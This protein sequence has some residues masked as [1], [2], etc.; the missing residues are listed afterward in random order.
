VETE[1]AT[2]TKQ[3]NLNREARLKEFEAQI[4]ELHG[5]ILSKNVAYGLTNDI[6]R[7]LEANPLQANISKT[8]LVRP[9]KFDTITRTKIITVYINFLDDEHYDGS[10]SIMARVVD[11]IQQLSGVPERPLS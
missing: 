3:V 9:K 7:L 8:T 2:D 6:A 5:L 1:N 10:R 11:E 4:H